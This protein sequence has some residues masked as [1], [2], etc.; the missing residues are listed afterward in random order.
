M[1]IHQCKAVTIDVGAAVDTQVLSAALTMDTLGGKSRG[2]TREIKVTIP[3]CTNVVTFAFAL[4]DP[5]SITRYSVTLLPR[6]DST[7]LLVE[8][9]IGENYKYGITASAVTGTA[10]TVSIY[11]DI[12]DD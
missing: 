5:Q 9:T 1:S 2:K 6:N 11:T 4:I 3:T 7:T 8:R 12:E 10:I